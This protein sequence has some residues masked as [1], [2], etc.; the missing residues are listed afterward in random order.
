MHCGACWVGHFLVVCL[1]GMAMHVGDSSLELSANAS[2]SNGK[3]ELSS[4]SAGSNGITNVMGVFV[5]TSSHESLEVHEQFLHSGDDHDDIP[6]CASFGREQW[7]DL[8]VVLFNELGALV[9]DGICRS[10]NTRECVDAN[11]FGLDDVG[12]CIINSLLPL[13]VPVTWRFSLRRWPLCQVLYEVVSL[14]DHEWRHKQTQL[15]LLAKIRPRKGLR[16]Y[17]SN[18]VPCRDKERR[19]DRLLED[20]YIRL[21]S[22]KNCCMRKCCQFFPREKIRSLSQEMWLANFR[23]RSAK[24]LEVHKNLHIN[25]HGYKVVTLKNVKVCC[26]AWYIIH[27]VSKA[28]FHRFESIHRW[29]TALDFIA[30][31]AQKNLGRLH[32]KHPRHSPPS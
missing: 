18:R 7:M 28:D 20:K 29:V 26:T 19:R 15:A 1:G 22:A 2:S 24:K 21:V 9:A 14:W 32:S 8:D 4:P 6:L 10:S 13:E 31:R 11:P 25:T 12:M 17:D 23:M 16:R 30:T 5:D 3:C 27:A